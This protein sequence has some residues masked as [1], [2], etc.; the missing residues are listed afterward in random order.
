VVFILT[1]PLSGVGR[2]AIDAMAIT[3]EF[4]FT[5]DAARRFYPERFHRDR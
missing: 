2:L 5:K 1:N 3:R 4:T